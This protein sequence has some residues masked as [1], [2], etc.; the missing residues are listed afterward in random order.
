[1]GAERD[2]RE[3]RKILW[4]KRYAPV[5]LRI[6]VYGEVDEKKTSQDII[7]QIGVM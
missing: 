3:A 2:K 6:L 7:F 1:M 4:F 5:I